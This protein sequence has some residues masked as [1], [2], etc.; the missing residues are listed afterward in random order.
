VSKSIFELVD[1]LPTSNLTVSM[2]KAL[3]FVAPG[4]WENTVGFVN[5]IKTVTGETDEDLI[6]QIVDE[7]MAGAGE[8]EEEKPEDQMVE[9]ASVK[10]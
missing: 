3:D 5:T 8:G 7:E 9:I 6:Q 2:L 1:E 10:M 4:E